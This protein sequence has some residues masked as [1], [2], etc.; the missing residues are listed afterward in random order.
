MNK[1]EGDDPRKSLRN[2]VKQSLA[3]PW[4][5]RLLLFVWKIVDSL[6]RD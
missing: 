1:S 3:S 6:N 2:R 4:F 5:F